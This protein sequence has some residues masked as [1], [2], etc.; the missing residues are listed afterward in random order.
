MISFDEA[1]RR[2]LARLEPIGKETLP[3]LASVGRVACEDL[4]ARVDSPTANASL[5]D[6]YALRSADVQDASEENPVRVRL[7]G[8]IAAGG[9]LTG[10]IGP[11]EA[12][13]ILSGGRVP[14]GADAVLAEEFT[15]E[16]DGWLVAL[17]TAR[18]GRNILPARADIFVGKELV[19]KGERLTPVKVGLLASAGFAQVPVCRQP[20]VAVIATGDEVVAPGK[21]LPDGKLYA[22][23]L[24]TLAGWCVSFGFDVQTFVVPDDRDKIQ[25]ALEE[26][27][28]NF[29]VALTSGGAWKSDRD[30]VVH[31]L[32]ALGW[33]KVYHRIKMGPGKAVGFGLYQGKSV[34]LLP[35]GPP[36]NHMAFL[37][38][39]VP[40]MHRMAGW[41]ELG[42]PLVPARVGKTL[43]GQID[44][45]Q[46]EHGRLEKASDGAAVFYPSR[47]TSRLQMMAASNAVAKIPEGV[48]CIP[49]G[50][51]ILVQK[52]S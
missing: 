39:V 7:V 6:G 45:T 19:A 50:E 15:R 11:G 33:E 51:T 4:V 14:D 46:F 17:G 16:E 42:F 5:K 3:L 49:E 38:L 47:Q 12:V 30:L 35:G 21:P 41:P 23:N 31:I 29:D 20:R 25:A 8:K 22:S 44:W 43:R 37:Q 52:L 28:V 36:S 48:D 40:A 26:A 27:L 34:F 13:R 18:L 1:Y 10:M 2:T 24:V 9:D 32:D